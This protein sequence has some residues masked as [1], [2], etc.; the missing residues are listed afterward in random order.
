MASLSVDPWQEVGCH[1]AGHTLDMM[2]QQGAATG[3]QGAATRGGGGVFR[4]GEQELFDPGQSQVKIK[5]K[6]QVRLAFDSS[7]PPPPLEAQPAY[8][9]VVG[10][11]RAEDDWQTKHMN[12]GSLDKELKTFARLML[13]DGL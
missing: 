1:T 13:R 3:G 4:V 2:I 7:P 5:G 10:T 12:A 9:P 8:S 11:P 6:Q